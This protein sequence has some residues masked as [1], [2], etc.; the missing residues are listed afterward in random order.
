MKG[1]ACFAVLAAT[2]AT[3]AR[4]QAPAPQD[5]AQTVRELT[6]RNEY[7]LC[8][9]SKGGA[10]G[11]RRWCAVA[12]RAEHCKAWTA[13]CDDPALPAGATPTWAP[14]AKSLQGG[15]AQ[16]A[17]PQARSRAERADNA[18][19]APAALPWLRDIL[20][21]AVLA[22]V[23]WIA[24]KLFRLWRSLPAAQPKPQASDAPAQ[25][26]LVDLD[27]PNALPE[28]DAALAR[29]QQ[30]AAT[31]PGQSLAWLYAAALRN[32][33]DNG[34]LRW[35]PA[36]SNRAALR[37]LDRDLPLR[38]P[39]RGLV[40]RLEQWRFGGR[41]PDAADAHAALHAIAPL[42]KASTV[43]LLALAVAA[44][45]PK[46]DT[47]VVGRALTWDLLRAHGWEIAGH[48][49]SLREVDGATPTL[50]V[51]AEVATVHATML[52]ELRDAACR[53]GHV[54]L[55]A[56]HPQSLAPLDGAV[57]DLA[58]PPTLAGAFGPMEPSRGPPGRQVVLPLKYAVSDAPSTAA[59]LQAE[60]ANL[61]PESDPLPPSDPPEVPVP[62]CA[63][64]RQS[65]PLLWQDD[66]PAALR[67]RATGGGSLV[68]VAD[69]DLLANAAMTVPDNARA[70]I[71]LAGDTAPQHKLALMV[72]QSAP[73][74][75]DAADALGAAGMVPFLAQGALVLLIAAWMRAARFGAARAQQAD[76]RRAFTD[77]I[78]A[79]AQLLRARTATHWPAAQVC[80]YGLDRLQRRLGPADLA[81]LAE[82]AAATRSGGEARTILRLLQK[83]EALRA[84]P[85]GADHPQD[86]PTAQA[87]DALVTG[88][89]HKQ[90]SA[91][92]PARPPKGRP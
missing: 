18:A 51:D 84:S 37:L 40:A 61:L 81:T 26:T 62:A 19:D 52:A 63:L 73:P 91:S 69:N 50:W 27:N 78:A 29:A 88:V 83:A 56:S 67:W 57:V 34:A 74:A 43:A 6:G 53:G 42:L 68:V 92:R 25:I 7:W 41:P 30:L 3:D 2:L 86:L 54:V 55:F 17:S 49:L 65:V 58:A 23:G 5:P 11:Q 90:P 87:L 80:A 10:D 70:L 16:G 38:A 82:R 72:P 60:L 79:V 89:E 9:R 85:N 39:L 48:R 14:A 71:A 76:Q 21:G 36:L 77:H 15:D 4:A 12:P 20:V 44:C 64:Q 32:L 46:G 28:V 47:T 35:H 33:H 66:Q 45:S 59:A 22:L 8:E 24:W 1:F 75:T 31:Q 13:H